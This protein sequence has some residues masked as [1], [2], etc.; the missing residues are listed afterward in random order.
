[1]LNLNAMYGTEI[2]HVKGLKFVDLKPLKKRNSGSF[3]AILYPEDAERLKAAGWD[4]KEYVRPI[5]PDGPIE[6]SIPIYV[7]YYDMEGNLKPENYI[8]HIS[9]DADGVRTFLSPD[10][11]ANL[12]DYRFIDAAL[13]INPNRKKKDPNRVTAYLDQALFYLDTNPPTSA[14]GYVDRWADRYK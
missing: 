8:P 11:V 3:N 12:G 7:N 6:Y 10:E 14:T 1:M 2:E 5:D 13:V 4:I 9:Q